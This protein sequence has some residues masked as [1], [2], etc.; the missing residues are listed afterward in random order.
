MKI[1]N[2]RPV[3]LTL[4]RETL[5]ALSVKSKVRAGFMPYSVG[6]CPVTDS[7]AKVHG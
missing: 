4:A 5:R 3:T 6:A 2:E 7:C 1:A